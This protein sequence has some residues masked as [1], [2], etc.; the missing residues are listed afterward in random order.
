[1][2]RDEGLAGEKDGDRRRELYIWTSGEAARKHKY[3]EKETH[4]HT[5]ANGYFPV[6]F[7]SHFT[8]VNNIP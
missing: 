2:I 6:L 4:K 1:M 8:V 3:A 7:Y 5:H